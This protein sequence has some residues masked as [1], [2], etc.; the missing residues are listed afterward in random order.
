MKDEQLIKR[1]LKTVMVLIGIAVLFKF[2]YDLFQVIYFNNNV[3]AS[4][5]SFPDAIHFFLDAIVLLSYLLFIVASL[6]VARKLMR[7]NMMGFAFLLSGIAILYRLIVEIYYIIVW[8]LSDA[9]I[10]AN[11]SNNEREVL[12]AMII[13]CSIIYVVAFLIIIFDKKADLGLRLAS[14]G[15]IA[16]VVFVFFTRNLAIDIHIWVQNY[17]LKKLLSN[18]IY[19]LITNLAFNVGMILLF[20]LSSQL[21][22]KRN[23]AIVQGQNYGT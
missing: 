6:F 15:L 3:N 19:V 20:A 11:A 14:I 1:N 8:N 22:R 2:T 10:M 9:W 23:E 5:F 16:V 21:I 12:A 7:T 13:I 17:P 18:S 4:N